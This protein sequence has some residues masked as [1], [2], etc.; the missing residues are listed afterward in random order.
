MPT[1]PTIRPLR[2]D[3]LMAYRAIRLSGLKTSPEAFGSVYE[4]EAA[5]PAERYLP[6]LEAGEVFGAFVD[7]ALV[8]IATLSPQD[9]P[10][11]AHKAGVFGFYVEP[12][13]RGGGVGAALMSALITAATGRVEQLTL[14]V[15]EDN[16]PARALYERFGFTPYGREPRALKTANGYADELLMVL[17]L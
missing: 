11:D 4:I 7:E 1:A 15:V 12:G 5:R 16:L 14:A 17:F 3:E 9:G 6:R 8:G 13:Y 10:K 2:P